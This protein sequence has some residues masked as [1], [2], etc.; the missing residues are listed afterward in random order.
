MKTS[1]SKILASGAK[2][3]KQVVRGKGISSVDRGNAYHK[4][5]ENAKA[6]LASVVAGRPEV[7][8]GKFINSI[9]I[10]STMSPSVKVALSEVAE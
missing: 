9:S 10:T 8:K 2:P 6:A 1:V 4:L 3:E 7:I 5:L